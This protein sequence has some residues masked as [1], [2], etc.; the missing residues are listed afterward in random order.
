MSLVAY[1]NAQTYSFSDDWKASGVLQKHI[2][3]TFGVC[4][5]TST[6]VHEILDRSSHIWPIRKGSNRNT[7][8][9]ATKC[10]SRLALCLALI[11]RDWDRIPLHDFGTADRSFWIVRY[12]SCCE[13]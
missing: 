3:H 11:S 7:A 5:W 4:R 10:R 13:Q 6:L 12:V 1:T 2:A 8:A 9:I